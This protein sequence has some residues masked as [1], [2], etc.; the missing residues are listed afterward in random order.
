MSSNNPTPIDDIVSIKYSASTTTLQFRD[1]WSNSLSNY[2]YLCP[3]GSFHPFEF[4]YGHDSIF[5]VSLAPQIRE[6]IATFVVDPNVLTTSQYL[7]Q[8]NLEGKHVRLPLRGSGIPQPLNATL[9]GITE[10]F[11]SINEGL[12]NVDGTASR[13]LLRHEHVSRSRPHVSAWPRITLLPKDRYA[14]CNRIP[15]TVFSGLV[16]QAC[17]L[18]AHLGTRSAALANLTWEI[19]LFRPT[20]YDVAPFVDIGCPENTVRLLNA[21][22]APWGVMLLLK[23]INNLTHLQLHILSTG[24]ALPNADNNYLGSLSLHTYLA[25]RLIQSKG[26]LASTLHQIRNDWGKS[27]HPSGLRFLDSSDSLNYS[28]P[29]VSSFEPLSSPLGIEIT[30][31]ANCIMRSSY[32]EI[33]EVDNNGVSRDRVIMHDISP[34][35]SRTAGFHTAWIADLFEE[36]LRRR[37]FYAIFRSYHVH[38]SLYKIKLF[39]VHVHMSDP[40]FLTEPFRVQYDMIHRQSPNRPYQGIRNMTHVLPDWPVLFPYTAQN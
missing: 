4:P 26:R 37:R 20:G 34:V 10:L 3:E 1:Y 39:F 27:I 23:P 24:G 21:G 13:D 15:K 12:R 29:R 6:G 33:V 9:H 25:E 19:G 11:S 22:H 32:S 36:I 30:L 5:D 17:A 8:R 14:E 7:T 18:R 2:N 40:I 38:N 28:N 16:A 31:P 35:L